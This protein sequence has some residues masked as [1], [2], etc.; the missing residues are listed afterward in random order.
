V[1]IPSKK[2]LDMLFQYYDSD[3]SGYLDYK[4]FTSILVGKEQDTKSNM[5]KKND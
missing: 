4:E 5:E 1:A 3:G 2:D